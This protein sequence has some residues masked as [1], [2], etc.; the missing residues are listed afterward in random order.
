MEIALEAV[1]EA[2]RGLTDGSAINS[3]TAGYARTHGDT[4]AVRLKRP[5]ATKRGASR[6]A[7]TRVE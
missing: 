3:R 2:F 5:A 1:Q 6:S 4:L 7:A